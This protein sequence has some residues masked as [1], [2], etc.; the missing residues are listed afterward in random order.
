MLSSSLK[1]FFCWLQ[2]SK[3]QEIYFLNFSVLNKMHNRKTSVHKHAN[4]QLAQVFIWRC[5]LRCPQKEKLN[6]VWCINQSFKYLFAKPWLQVNLF[7]SFKSQITRC[8]L[9]KICIACSCSLFPWRNGSEKEGSSERRFAKP[10][11]N[12]DWLWPKDPQ[13]QAHL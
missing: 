8:E 9:S 13:E 2:I 10:M 4:S 1:T 6:N 12:R 3:G 11:Q 7:R 5:E